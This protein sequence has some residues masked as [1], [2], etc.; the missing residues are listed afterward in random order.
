[1]KDGGL[2]NLAYSGDGKLLATNPANDVVVV[3]AATLKVVRTFDMESHG[4]P[5]WVAMSPKGHLLASGNGDGTVVF[6][7]T[8]DW[9]HVGTIQAATDGIVTM[10][11][12]PTGHQL[13]VRSGSATTLWDISS[14]RQ[15]GNALD[16]IFAWGT[17]TFIGSGA[18]TS[19]LATMGYGQAF[20]YPA[21]A[22]GWERQACA[23]AGR[24]LTK[25]EWERYV[26]NAP[27]QKTCPE[28]P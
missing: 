21:T 24:N 18:S 11:F 28:F 19:V 4:G 26:G 20:V 2:G 25:A 13:V 16:T 17:A 8:T 15:L 7:R 3:D 1:M 9:K 5:Y 27:V 6:W 14:G 22:A 12:D 23:V 10:A